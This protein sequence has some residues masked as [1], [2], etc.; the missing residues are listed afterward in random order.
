LQFGS[1]G[2]IPFSWGTCLFSPRSFN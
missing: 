2:R 1:E